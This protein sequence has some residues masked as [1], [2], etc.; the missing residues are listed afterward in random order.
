[1]TLHL[2]FGR[3]KGAATYKV[4]DPAGHEMPI[5]FQYDTRKGGLTGF[6]LP[7][8]DGVLTWPELVAYWPEFLKTKVPA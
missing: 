4:H 5:G 6:T 2:S 8:R 3:G 1:M 7:G